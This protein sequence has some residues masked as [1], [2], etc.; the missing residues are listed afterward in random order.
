MEIAIEII[1]ICCFIVLVMELLLTTWAK[2]TIRL[3]PQHALPDLR[4][5]NESMFM[6]LLRTCRR[7]TVGGYFLSFW[8]FLDLINIIVLMFDI[9]WAE[10]KKSEWAMYRQGGQFAAVIICYIRARVRCL[11]M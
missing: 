11:P 1:N 5:D 7:V 8:F 3:K 2:S 6:K 10:L 9:Q 4:M